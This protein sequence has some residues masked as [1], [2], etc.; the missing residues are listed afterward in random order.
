MERVFLQPIWSGI[1]GG[2]AGPTLES[3]WRYLGWAARPSYGELPCPEWPP[4]LFALCAAALRKSGAYTLPIS[5]LLERRKEK[6]GEK[7]ETVESIGKEWRQNVGERLLRLRGGDQCATEELPQLVPKT[8]LE[9]WNRSTEKS[10]LLLAIS[11]LIDDEPLVSDLLDMLAI[12]DEACAGVGLPMNPAIDED[13]ARSKSYRVRHAFHDWAQQILFPTQFGSTLCRYV[14]PSIARVLPKMH[15]AQYGLTIRSFSNNLAFCESEEVQPAWLAVPGARGDV[16]NIHHLNVLIAPWPKVVTPAQIRPSE[17][18]PESGGNKR[19]RVRCFSFDPA[20]TDLHVA[21]EL[22]AL[23]QE[24]ERIIG[25]LDAVVM[26]ELSLTHED[27]RGARAAL[28]RRGLMFVAGVGASDPPGNYL[29]MDVPLSKYHAVHLRQRKHHRWKLENNQIKQYGLGARLNPQ[30]DYWEQIAVNDRK[31]VFLALRP[32]LVT[33]AL[34]CEDLARHDPVGELIR[35]VGPNLVIALLMDGPQLSSRWASRYAA[36]LTDDPGCSVLSVTSV[37][38][39]ELSRPERN[40]VKPS[41][42]VALWKDQFSGTRELELP[43]GTDGLVITLAV[44]WREERTADLR[45]DLGAAGCPQLA[46]VHP[47]V[48][49]NPVPQL[50]VLPKTGWISLH[51]AAVLSRLAQQPNLQA[52]VLPSEVAALTGEAFQ[53]GREIWRLAANS[54]EFVDDPSWANEKQRETAERIHRWH[55]TNLLNVTGE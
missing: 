13:H 28:L 18:T 22:D 11:R 48:L 10:K 34:I 3:L 41:R 31:L 19:A 15:T 53:I 39:A 16:E 42:V 1:E 7:N 54:D 38:M 6:G 12:A 45:S 40:D 51:D 20:D 14:H 17:E 46:G 26:P 44:K 23:A 47:V 25:P 49:P 29:A 8:L 9:C 37:G 5:E 50:Q 4:D 52:D 30:Y 32:W 27:Y 33:T 35:G 2:G 43:A 36:G 21:S 24:A 55:K